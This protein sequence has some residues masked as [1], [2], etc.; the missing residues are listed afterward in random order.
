L[1]HLS[2]FLIFSGLRVSPPPPLLFRLR[3]G[4][5]LFPLSLANDGCSLGVPLRRSDPHPRITGRPFSSRDHRWGPF[6]FVLSLVVPPKP[7][8]IST[9]SI[10]Q[11]DWDGFGLLRSRISPLMSWGSE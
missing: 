11:P 9:E 4:F 2:L 10:F 8:L 1:K 6:F 5:F 7:F 3:I